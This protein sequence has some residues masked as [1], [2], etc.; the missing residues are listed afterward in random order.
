MSHLQKIVEDLPIK[1]LEARKKM[2]QSV[3]SETWKETKAFCGLQ[4]PTLE[5]ILLVLLDIEEGLRMLHCRKDYIHLRGQ[6]TAIMRHEMDMISR[7]YFCHADEHDDYILRMLWESNDSVWLLKTEHMSAD[8]QWHFLLRVYDFMKQIY[9][10]DIK[11][12][13]YPNA[14]ADIEQVSTTFQKRLL[15]WENRFDF[16]RRLHLYLHYMLEFWPQDRQVRTHCFS[17]EAFVWA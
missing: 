13:P 10:A 11:S 7:C 9:S 14:R 5:S 15:Q 1:L 3:Q 2:H 12:E 8:R 16:L 6:L 4:R 17:N